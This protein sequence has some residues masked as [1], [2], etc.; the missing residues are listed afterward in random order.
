[1]TAGQISVALAL[2]LAVV[3][4]AE[5]KAPPDCPPG[6]S[7]VS[8][9]KV[10][11]QDIALAKI[12]EGAGD[13]KDAE[14]HFVAAAADPSARN[15]AL[16]G[17]RT[18][19]VEIDKAQS[20]ILDAGSKY[21]KAHLWS[22]AED[23]YRA[24]AVDPNAGI[25]VRCK[26]V[27]RLEFV[28]REQE[29]SRGFDEGWERLKK[30]VEAAAAF[31]GVLLLVAGLRSISKGRRRI[32]LHN[33]SAPNEELAAIVAMHLKYARQTML[34]PSLS[35]A[36]QMPTTLNIFQFEDESEGIE[37]IEVAGTA[38][39]LAA[40]SKLFATPAVTVRGGFDGLDPLADI[41]AVLQT[42]KGGEDSILGTVRMTQPL[43]K[44]TDLRTFAYTVLVRATTAQQ[45]AAGSIWRF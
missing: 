41:W 1:M 15:E 9:V 25:S 43:E 28:L 34:S 24:I 23:I 35:I 29:G 10:P 32:V 36:Y 21:E 27:K 30:V 17:V 42:R 14:I 40:L 4:V 22:K 37:D 38:I 5:V 7:S 45:L 44:R 18:S 31:I 26:A 6:Q 33:F 20:L 11:N 19:H 12:Y 3:S 8:P 2:A 16:E 39:P 13:W